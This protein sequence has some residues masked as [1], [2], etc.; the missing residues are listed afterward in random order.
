MAETDP[1][2][3]RRDFPI[4]A[5][6]EDDVA[7]REFLRYLTLASC[8][9]AA[10]GVGVAAWTSLREPDTGEPQPIVALDDVPIGDAYLFRY[11]GKDDPA[12]L[13]RHGRDDVHAFSQKCT[14]LGCV[15]MWTD[16]SPDLV[17]PCH[18][19]F[20]D[21]DTGAVLAGPPQ[22]PLPRIITE[23][24]DDTIWAIEREAL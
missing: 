5:G 21:A 13:I 2:I 16:A 22:R 23:I 11:P 14:H 8:A 18:E 17:C 19:G 15:V 3:W 6:D 9:F 20:F 24:R 10:G 4:G 7:R 12:I 1:E